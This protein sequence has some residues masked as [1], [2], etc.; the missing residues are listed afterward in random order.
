M[1]PRCPSSSRVVI[2]HSF[3]GK[4]GQYFSTSASNSSFPRSASRRIAVAVMGFEIAPSRK[5]VERRNEVLEMG[6]SET[7]GPDQLSVLDDCNG[8]SRHAIRGRETP[9][10]LFRLA[11]AFRRK[12]SCSALAMSKSRRKRPATR[13]QTSRW[14][15]LCS[16][17]ERCESLSRETPRVRVY[18]GPG[19]DRNRHGTARGLRAC[20]E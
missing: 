19:L 2:G 11:R 10:L 9:C 5:S 1:P 17:N 14:S 15:C 6:H 3:F 18:P 4:A 7:L 20:I 16:E 12:N 8:N 13:A